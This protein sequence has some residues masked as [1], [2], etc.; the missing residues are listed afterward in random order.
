VLVVEDD[1][2]L[3]HLVAR[4]L[5]VRGHQVRQAAD[6]QEALRARRQERPDVLVLDINLPDATGWDLLRSIDLSG[7]TTVVVLTAV[8]MSPRRLSELKPLIFLP[9]PFPLDALIRVID[10][11]CSD[12]DEPRRG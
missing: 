7:A 4:N 9:K 1:G 2:T 12:E 8:A 6:A 11:W 5:A 3:R 10:T